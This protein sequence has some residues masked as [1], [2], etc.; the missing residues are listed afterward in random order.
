MSYTYIGHSGLERCGCGYN[1]TPQSM[2]EHK[3]DGCE[4]GGK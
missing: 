2:K 1:D 4:G 3:E